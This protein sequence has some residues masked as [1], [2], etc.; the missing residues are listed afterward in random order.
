MVGADRRHSILVK[1]ARMPGVRGLA[2]S[3]DKK[4]KNENGDQMQ[5]NSTK[6]EW[7]E[8]VV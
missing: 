5:G 7:N 8:K 1:T 3:N 6:Q 4:N 2:N